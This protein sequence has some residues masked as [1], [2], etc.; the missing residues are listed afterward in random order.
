MKELP[1]V[2]KVR[3]KRY[4]YISQIS[5]K[6]TPNLLK[7]DFK[8]DEPNI[9]W[10]TDVSEFRFNRKRLYLS[11][12]QDL[13]NGEVKGY[14]ISRSQNQDLILKTLKKSINPNEDLSK[15]LMHSGQG[16]LYQSPKYRNYRKKSSFTQ[17]ISTK[18]NAY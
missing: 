3:K 6:I 13:Y 11:V 16:I 18:G 4:R 2:C 9:A 14:Q 12:I 15:L 17:S 5:N 10:V 7:R 1:I 8:K